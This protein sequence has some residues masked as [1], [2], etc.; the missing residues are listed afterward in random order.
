MRVLFVTGGNTE[1]F[2]IPPLIKAQGESLKKNGIDIEY[3]P[4]VGKGFKGYIKNIT[5]L[6]KYVKDNSVNI[7][8]AHFSFA[9]IVAKLAK[10]NKPIVLSLLGSDAVGK[11]IIRRLMRWFV[12]ILSWESL[13]VKSEEMAE[14]IKKG[15]VRII[16]NGVDLAKFN[17][18]SD[19]KANLKHKL[20][21][22]IDKKHILF[23]AN[24][25][26]PE[27]NYR[28][29]LEAL[30]IIKNKNITLHY[31]ENVRHEDISILMN[32][33]D[34]VALS[35]LWEGSPN[36]IK[37]AMACNRPIV[38]TDVGDVKWLFDDE[39]GYYLTDFTPSDY[40]EKLNMALKYS[41][42]NNKTSGRDRI[43]KL[44]IDSESIAKSIIS[45][46]EKLK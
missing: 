15:S 16:P 43:I 34:V 11:G 13:I 44:G 4:I 8:H 23:A 33:A 37:E 1:K 12:N 27:K 14:K 32:A 30:E 20:N 2:G 25:N 10:T 46:Y 18:L 19:I 9:G 17:D 40:A 24:P 31:L 42:D 22:D 21:W 7:I 28:L 26:R 3:F 6:K 29:I 45:I 36:V 39:P 38:S 41:K 35:S 5:K